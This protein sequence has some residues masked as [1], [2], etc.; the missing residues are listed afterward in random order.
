MAD[1]ITLPSQLRAG[2][3]WRWTLTLPDYA[4]WSLVCAFRSATAHFDVAATV[5]GDVFTFTASPAVNGA[6]APGDY[7]AYLFAEQYDGDTLTDR[8]ELASAPV[9]LL[10]NVAL[11][12]AHDA[13]STLRR[14]LDAID[15]AL[16]N[17]ATGDQLDIIQIQSGDKNIVKDKAAL[18]EWRSK[19]ALEVA[20]EEAAAAGRG[21]AVNI[22]AS[23]R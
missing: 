8:V 7:T 22:V 2:T 16:L 23:F 21:R 20:R 9:T 1:P 15:A 6:Y 11:A 17:R 4:G 12:A 18:M 13:R 19:I 10:P 3:S 14:V 5:D